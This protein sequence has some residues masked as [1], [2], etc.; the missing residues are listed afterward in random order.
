MGFCRIWDQTVVPVKPPEE[1]REAVALTIDICIRKGYLAK[2]FEEHRAE[3][4][5]IMLTMLS[6]EYVR[7]ASERTQ[8]I[9]QDISAYRYAEMPEDKIKALII[10]HYDLTPTYAQNFLDDDS[11]PDDSTPDAI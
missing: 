10:R 4:E 11:D 3:V 6:P 8:K 2:Y 9:K 5:K 7:M 1:K